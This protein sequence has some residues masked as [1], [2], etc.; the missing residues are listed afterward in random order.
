MST[1]IMLT[2]IAHMGTPT[3]EALEPLEREV[4]DHVRAAC[5]EVQWRDSYAV[6]G[7]YDYL[8]IFEAP[9]AEMATK[10]ATLV[11]TY[12]HADAEVWPATAWGRFKDMLHTIPQR[13][14]ARPTPEMDISM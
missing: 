3:P 8:D 11:R 4:M 14:Q 12:G 7:P 9:D 5:P 2:H 10:V 13:I 6:L 1:F